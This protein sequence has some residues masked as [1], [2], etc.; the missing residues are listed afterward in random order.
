[1]TTQAEAQSKAQPEMVNGQSAWF[2]I[3]VADLGKA[4]TFYEAV[5]NTKMIRTT[6][7]SAP[8]EMV[9]FND[10]SAPV[11]SGHLYPGKPSDVGTG[12]TVHMVALDPLEEV[13][14]RVEPAGGKVVSPVIPIPAGRF[15]YITD[16]DGNSI[17]LFN[18]SL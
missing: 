17:G 5:L 15:V 12:N 11:V 3:P 1:M 6:D 14:T 9:W 18:G 2:E 16:P 4:Q 13:M 10:P 8:N 7:P